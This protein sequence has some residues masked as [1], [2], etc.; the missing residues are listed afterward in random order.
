MV[1]YLSHLQFTNDVKFFTAHFKGLYRFAKLDAQQYAYDVA[2]RLSRTIVH[3]IDTYRTAI[4]A[5]KQ[6]E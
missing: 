3:L 4:S 6:K 5:L 2:E 1:Q